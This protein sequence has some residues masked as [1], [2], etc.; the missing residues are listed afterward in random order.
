MTTRYDW[1]H[2]LIIT[3]F[4]IFLQ[5]CLVPRSQLD[6]ANTDLEVARDRIDSLESDVANRDDN[7]SRLNSDLA[8]SADE[9]KNLKSKER[10]LT[11]KLNV[12]NRERF[13]LENRISNLKS[14]LEK[15]KKNITVNS[16]ERDSASNQIVIDILDEVVLCLN[17]HDYNG[18]HRMLNL[19]M[20][21]K[22]GQENLDQLA[23]ENKRIIDIE[24]ADN[25]S[26][27]VLKKLELLIEGEK[28]EDACILYSSYLDEFY[29]FNND[30]KS[31][32]RA[33]RDKITK[34]WTGLP[35]KRIEEL[36]NFLSEAVVPEE[37]VEEIEEEEPHPEGMI[38]VES[39]NYT[40]GFK[41]GIRDESKEHQA[42]VNQ[43]WIDKH[44]VTNRDYAVFLNE[45]PQHKVPLLWKNGNY[46]PGTADHPVVGISYREALAYAEWSG[47][48]LPTAVEW[49]AAARGPATSISRSPIYPWGDQWDP[50]ICN[51]GRGK[52]EPVDSYEIGASKYGCLSM[53]GNAAEFVLK[54]PGDN[55]VIAL[56]GSAALIQD[57]NPTYNE[58]IFARPSLRENRLRDDKRDR[59][60]GFRCAMDVTTSEDS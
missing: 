56:G 27:E 18:A 51:I 47:K 8:T 28:W 45:N 43:F 35:Q 40:I 6:Q 54:D 57:R 49:E 2:T 32:S 3:A 41:S 52:L 21:W 38:L 22:L 29:G 14:E 37:P 50:R 25:K 13:T 11:D 4:L 33:Y 7:L 60:I 55:A 42:T 34:I 16:D 23:R 59:F 12:A 9:N 17:E 44:E 19:A 24:Y 10:S 53:V 31:V 46:P 5:G 15:T 30:Q 1:C 39:G 36:N 48:R 26:K 20:K 58:M